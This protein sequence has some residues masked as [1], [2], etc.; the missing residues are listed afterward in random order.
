MD[1]LI[2]L[3][4]LVAPFISLAVTGL[5][6]YMNNSMRADIAN[7]KV[8]MAE[9]VA[10]TFTETLDKFNGRYVYA[11]LFEAKM[12]EIE[13]RLDALEDQTR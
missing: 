7:L 2:Q 1:N 6:A 8:E 9:K 3:G 11:I 12:K 4:P 5:I 10:K 13:R